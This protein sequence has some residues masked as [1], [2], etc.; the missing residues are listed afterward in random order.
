M[1]ILFGEILFFI[2]KNWKYV[3]FKEYKNQTNYTNKTKYANY[4]NQKNISEIIEEYLFPIPKKFD[5]DKNE[6][7]NRFRG[8]L[9]LKIMPKEQNA[10]L[11]LE[12]K[13]I[14]LNSFSK[15]AK[16]KTFTKLNTIYLTEPA[17]FGNRMQMLNNLIYYC[18]I[19]ECKNI[20][21]NP[22]HNWFI[23][24][25]VTT[26]KI[27]IA[28][29]K[30]SKIDCSDSTIYCISLWTGFCLNPMKIK[31]EIRINILKNE[32][33][34]NLP[35]IEID[36]NALYIHIRSGD[37]FSSY[38]NKFF[39][40]PPLCFYQTILNNFKYEKIY[41]ISKSDNNPVIGHLLKEF[42][43]I[44]YKKNDLN[45]DLAF[46]MKAYNLVGSVSTMLHSSI[47]LNNN[48]K[49]YWEYDIYRKSEKFSHL[50]F[51]IYEYERKFKIYKMMPSENYK[52]EMFSWK[53][54][55]SQLDL[56]IKEKCKNNFT[57]I[58]PN[59]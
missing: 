48:L 11:F 30:K 5:N 7:R 23:K 22:I 58:Y 27:N 37:I 15:Y 35:N 2:N 14:L 56:M 25:N 40:Q 54:S 19:M 3:I 21:L 20:Y 36:P 13:N 45:V 28:L 52:N 10:S 24:N 33:H 12:V 31:P 41:I 51:D 26:D 49:N 9:S 1:H 47:I 46:L 43:N 18:E 29:V 50:H 4:I 42:T 53:K 39:P 32:I 17:N 6:E 8:F 57:I 55:A 44:T 16:V 34:N 38:I 59:I